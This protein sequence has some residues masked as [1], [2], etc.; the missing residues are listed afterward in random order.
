MQSKA[1]KEGWSLNYV[2]GILCWHYFF[3]DGIP[4]KGCYPYDYVDASHFTP[5]AIFLLILMP[6]SMLP[7][8]LLLWCQ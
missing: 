7:S 3:K 6:L 4:A 1:L 8:D 5:A 2:R